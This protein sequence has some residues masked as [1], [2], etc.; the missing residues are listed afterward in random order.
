MI[1]M[2][3]AIT[4]KFLENFNDGLLKSWLESF[5]P[6]FLS[7][8]WSV[9]LALLVFYIG[10]KI[11]KVVRSAVRKS[12]EHRE[13]EKGVVQFIDGILRVLLWTADILIILQL[14]GLQTSSISAAIASVGVAAGLALQGS[15]S[16]F[17]G[18]VLILIF[19]PFQVGD[20][21]IED[22]NKN[23]GTVAEISIFYTKLKTIDNKIVVVPN[24]TLANASLTNVTMSDRRQLD[25]RVSIGYDADIK[26]A[27]G[28][29]ERLILEEDRRLQDHDPKIFVSELGESSVELGLRVWVPTDL[30]WDIRWDLLEKIKLTFDEENITIPFNQLDVHLV[31]EEN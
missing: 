31:K 12:L 25:L 27:K 20:Y 26:K 19:H 9:I 7:F 3:Q 24:G 6:E 13:I 4:D 22:T 2:S 14:F 29:L 18:G 23:E 11:I 5:L 21:I 28:I 17:A 30:Y 8:F 16:N 1:L 15:L 10:G